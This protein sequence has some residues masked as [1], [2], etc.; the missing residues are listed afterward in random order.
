MIVLLMNENNRE[1][2][3]TDLTGYLWKSAHR[4]F[5]NAQE[6]IIE[7]TQNP[8][9]P[10]ALVTIDLLQKLIGRGSVGTGNILEGRIGEVGMVLCWPKE[11]IMLLIGD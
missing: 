1:M 8:G 11:A 6:V 9:I 4:G 7:I 3:R 10:T 5:V 2:G